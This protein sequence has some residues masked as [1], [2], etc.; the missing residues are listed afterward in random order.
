[1]VHESLVSNNACTCNG[2]CHK[3][4]LTSNVNAMHYFPKSGNIRNYFALVCITM[5]IQFQNSDELK[6]WNCIWLKLLKSKE[7]ILEIKYLSSI[8]KKHFLKLAITLAITTQLSK[9][10]KSVVFKRVKR[11]KSLKK[12]LQL[13]VGLITSFMLRLCQHTMPSE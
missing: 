9:I 13:V 10:F 1:M 3:F 7:I 6:S 4:S 11:M 8:I 12:L 2:W 5:H